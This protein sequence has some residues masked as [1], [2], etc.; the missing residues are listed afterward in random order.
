MIT[1]LAKAVDLDLYKIPQ[2]AGFLVMA[3]AQVEALAANMVGMVAFRTEAN[4]VAVEQ[5]GTQHLQLTTLAKLNLEEPKT[6]AVL[7]LVVTQ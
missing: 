2:A 4:M 6:V 1:A 3:A 5:V 7:A